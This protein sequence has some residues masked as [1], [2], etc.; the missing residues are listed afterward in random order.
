MNQPAR[1][2]DRV[3]RDVERGEILDGD[4]RYLMIRADVLMGLFHRLDAPAAARALQ[5][6]ADSVHENGAKSARMYQRLG[7]GTGQS[8]SARLLSTIEATAPELGWGRWCLRFS[9]AEGETIDAS[10]QLLL[11]VENSPFAFGFGASSSAVCAPICGML[12]VL[13]EMVLGAPVTVVETRCRAV[14]GQGDCCFQVEK[15]DAATA[16][17]SPGQR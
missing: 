10:S 14:E 17:T 13:G 15:S 8:E 1:F 12:Q 9:Q 2:S 4:A 11:R 7:I 6:L 3:H 16:V 5:A